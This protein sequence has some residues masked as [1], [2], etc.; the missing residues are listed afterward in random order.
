MVTV[1]FELLAD[2]LL[3]CNTSM[4]YYEICTESSIEKPEDYTTEEIDSMKM[5]F[6]RVKNLKEK[7][8]IL[9]DEIYI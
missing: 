3:A 5:E 7:F 8:E 1:P 2:V 6:D 4:I 9:F